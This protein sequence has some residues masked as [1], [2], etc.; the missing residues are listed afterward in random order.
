MS[1]PT[2]TSAF[3]KA[4]QVGEQGARLKLLSFPS[5]TPATFAGLICQVCETLQSKILALASRNSSAHVGRL[6]TFISIYLVDQV[7]PALEYVEG[8]TSENTPANLVLPL[9]KIG[10][11]L[12]EGSKFIVRRQWRY[13]YRVV[14]VRKTLE[15]ALEGLLSREERERL[16]GPPSEK[17][18]A[19]SFP[20]FERDSALLH[21]NFAHEI[22]H[23]IEERYLEEESESEL[24]V[25]IEI[26]R[27]IERELPHTS[28]VDRAIKVGEAKGY[29]R[30]AIGEI[31]SDTLSAYVFGP[32]CLFALH[33]VAGLS[34]SMDVISADFHPP[35][36][37]RIRHMLSVL[38]EIGFI[39]M[40]Q[41]ALR[42]WPQGVPAS[43][44]RAKP[45]VDEWLQ[46]LGRVVSQQSDLAE[47]ERDVR[48]RCAYRS[49]QQAIP[50]IR[51]FVARNVTSP[52]TPQAFA[53][54]V[55]ELLDRIYMQL[56]PNQIESASG[57]VRTV[58]LASILA[59]GWIY[60]LAELTSFGEDEPANHT[61][62]VQTLNRLVLKAIEL[63]AVKAMYDAAFGRT[64][65]GPSQQ[66]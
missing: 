17:L 63:S 39:D 7:A 16:F 28:P 29:R 49:V 58:S 44:V 45:K 52:Y 22:G 30:V 38:G 50:A 15:S 62:R 21:V 34:R 36:R 60:K 47:I 33:E 2:A 27:D 6:L 14:E 53:E 40:N 19:I 12:L 54:E 5:P 37:F 59:S 46:D 43:V 32:S 66:P 61:L 48:T 65:N 9:E 8:A 42:T 13:N 1:D 11:A 24:L 31:I 35:W 57:Q 26:R 41:F 23:P 25:D 10:E 51:K 20:S 18:F 64:I 55:P 4:A 3:L 56:P